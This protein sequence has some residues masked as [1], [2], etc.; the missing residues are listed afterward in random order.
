MSVKPLKPLAT[1]ILVIQAAAI[2]L[3]SSLMAEPQWYACTAWGGS[4]TGRYT[5]RID[6]EACSVFWKELNARLEIQSCKP[7]RI[8]ALKPFAAN[9]DFVVEFNLSTGRFADYA[10]G[11]AD[12]GS[13]RP[14][15]HGSKPR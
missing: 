2:C 15:A 8:M 14:V 7:P 10:N 11:R 13:C 9:R 3:S 12:R 6:V 5:F 1:I 4:H